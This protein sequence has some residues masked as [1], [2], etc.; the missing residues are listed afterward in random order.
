MNS[1]CPPF[2]LFAALRFQC[3]PP[4]RR[5]FLQ[6]RGTLV[7]LLM[8]ILIVIGGGCSHSAPANIVTNEIARPV[9]EMADAVK[10]AK[11]FAGLFVKGSAPNEQQRKH[12]G[13]FAFQVSQLN[14]ISDTEANLDVSIDDGKSDQVSREEWTVA[15]EDGKWK[16]KTAP[17][18]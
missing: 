11:R 2:N 7:I 13:D 3:L 18:P 16:L 15:K 1:G 10:H 12:Y 17:L 4:A 9:Y 8:S 14:V 6:L 5:H